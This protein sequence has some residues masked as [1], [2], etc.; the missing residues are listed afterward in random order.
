MTES[1]AL[2]AA[3]DALAERWLGKHGVISITDDCEAGHPRIVVFVSDSANDPDR[4]L[5]TEFRGFPVV[6]RTGGPIV[7]HRQ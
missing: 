6:V 3:V 2:A 5:P 7:P 4:N 1:D